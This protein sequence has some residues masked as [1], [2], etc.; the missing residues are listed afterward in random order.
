[1]PGKADTRHW[2]ASTFSGCSLSDEAATKY[3]A[4]LRKDAPLFRRASRCV[5]FFSES[6]VCTRFRVRKRT[7]A[8]CAGGVEVRVTDALDT[9]V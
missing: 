9:L 8:A 3:S 5:R 6:R 2:R 4:Q 1:M 7:W